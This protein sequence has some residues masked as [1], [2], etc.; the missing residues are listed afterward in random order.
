MTALLEYTLTA[1]F[2][3]IFKR[4]LVLPHIL[5]VESIAIQPCAVLLIYSIS[6]QI[7]VL[8]LACCKLKI[9]NFTRV[10]PPHWRAYAK[11]F[12]HKGSSTSTSGGTHVSR[13]TS[14]NVPYNPWWRLCTIYNLYA[15]S[16]R[17]EY[18]KII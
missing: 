2:K 15:S 8:G 5:K 7:S 12:W 18:N 14:S 17:M 3:C 6:C 4:A 16:K 13:G 9:P 11:G 10:P 1:L